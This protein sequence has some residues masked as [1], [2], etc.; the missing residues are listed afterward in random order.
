MGA[1]KKKFTEG[2]AE[3][4]LDTLFFDFTDLA[5]TLK[6]KIVVAENVKGILLGN[7]KKY[8]RRIYEELD[9]AGYYAQHFLLDASKM[10]IPQKRARIFIGLRK[11]LAMPFLVQKD[12]F[13]KA[14]QIDLSF[15]C[16]P[17]LFEKIHESNAIG[18]KEPAPYIKKTLE[19]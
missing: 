6:P 2:Q 7:A 15:N 14:P 19:R 1:L 10:G 16:K 11:D 8:V 9:K 4:I 5:A 17:I 12:I 3:Q 18:L 13:T